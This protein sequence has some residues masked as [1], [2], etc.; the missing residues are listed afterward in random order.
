MRHTSTLFCR[1]LSTCFKTLDAFSIAVIQAYPDAIHLPTATE[2]EEIATNMYAERGM[3]G[4]LGGMDGKHFQ[5]TA[6]ADDDVSL[7]NYKGFR[8]LT[9][10]A[11]ANHVYK[12]IWMSDVWP[13]TILTLL[14]GWWVC[15]SFYL[16]FFIDRNFFD[17]VDVRRA[18]VEP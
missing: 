13:G 11:I 4:C 5:I 3:P 14:Y 1:G 7:K 15:Y 16:I 8:S 9:V 2:C 17:R 18:N 6:G 12:F 10:L